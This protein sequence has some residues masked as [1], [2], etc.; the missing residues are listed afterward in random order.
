MPLG[1]D[2]PHGDMPR[3]YRGCMAD[4]EPPESQPTHALWR[5]WVPLAWGVPAAAFGIRALTPDAGWETLILMLF[6]P[7]WYPILCVLGLLPRWIWRARAGT[8]S[9]APAPLMGLMVVHWGA[10]LLAAC[11]LRGAGDSSSMDSTLLQLFPVL[12]E[13]AE[14]VVFG[15][16][17]PLAVLSLV[18]AIVVAGAAGT[19]T[20]AASHGS[21]RGAWITVA[22]LL[23]P[24]VIVA[25]AAV[26]QLSRMHGERD[27]AGRT[28]LQATRM[29]IAETAAAQ[30]AAWEQTQL[31]AQPVRA[32]V[33]AEHWMVLG[34]SGLTSYELPDTQWRATADWRTRVD[35]DLESVAERVRTTLAAEGWRAN[36]AGIEGREWVLEHGGEARE[37]AATFEAH[38]PAP[39]DAENPRPG[40]PATGPTVWL[41]AIHDDGSL[42]TI[43]LQAAPGGE[44][45]TVDV[46][47][48]SPAYW[49]EDTRFW[50]GNRY[51]DIV[52]TEEL[53]VPPAGF[54]ASEWP[55]LAPMERSRL[56]V[57]SEQDLDSWLE[58]STDSGA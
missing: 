12:D 9:G 40:R 28:E 36:P 27:H 22:A 39:G 25:G 41:W 46:T 57:E 24:A 51:P 23:L 47:V 37:T 35:E 6:A 53:V 11:S 31:L 33:T 10:L 4:A 45:T 8:L 20:G 52:G 50:W 2:M 21:R 19:R 13:R 56:S 15:I 14:N 55:D 18:A 26:S 49:G 42:A 54:A 17:V 58:S 5:W 32:S 48:D 38:E 34:T 1:V 3:P 44:S 29:S 16:A 30:R 43:M 7:L